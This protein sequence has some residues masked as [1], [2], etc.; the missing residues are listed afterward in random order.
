MTSASMVLQH[1]VRLA[2]PSMWSPKVC[3]HSGHLF[4]MKHSRAH[5][6]KD[7][8][9]HATGESCHCAAGIARL[10]RPRDGRSSDLRVLRIAV[11]SMA[12]AAVSCVPLHD[13]ENQ[14]SRFL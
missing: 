13:H 10:A 5:R 1:L 9:S 14:L 12:A 2:M 4:C 7:D 3:G 6:L 8:W 11:Y